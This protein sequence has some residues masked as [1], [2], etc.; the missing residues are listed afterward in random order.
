MDYQITAIAPQYRNP[1]PHYGIA[2]QLGMRIN[3]DQFGNDYAYQVIAELGKAKTL[4]STLLHYQYGVKIWTTDGVT[5][6]P[7]SIRGLF[8]TR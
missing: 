4:V 1:K 3:Q 7:L 2:T 5:G 6:Q 8:E